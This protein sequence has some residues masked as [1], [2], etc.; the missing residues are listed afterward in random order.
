L[1]AT[2]GLFGALVKAGVHGIIGG[3]LSV[4]QG[5]SFLQGFAGSA[6]GALGGYFA[7]GSGL[8]PGHYG[9]GVPE[10][11]LARALVSGA[12]GCLGAVV[13][14]GK[15]AEAAL[16]AAFASIYNADRPKTGF[17]GTGPGSNYYEEP[18]PARTRPGAGAVGW[19]GLIVLGA[20]LLPPP[21][22]TASWLADD[23]HNMLDPIAQKQRVTAVVSTAEGEFVVAGGARDL[24]PAQRARAAELGVSTAKWPGEH[25]EMTAILGAMGKDLTVTSIGI[26]GSSPGFCSACRSF[27][28][29]NGFRITSDYT[30]ARR[31]K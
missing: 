19:G 14:G 22:S 3:A 2:Q 5:G 6:A 17:G 27:L 30:A 20:S 9:D 11:M 25:A 1:V 8:T 15:C 31:V 29:L 16:T 21:G 24:S 7:D 10:N 28:Q 4:A 23:V 12:A 18:M 13:T 26:N